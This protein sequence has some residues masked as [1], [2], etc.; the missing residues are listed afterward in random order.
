MRRSNKKITNKSN[1]S[2]RSNKNNKREKLVEIK[3]EPQ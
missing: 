1:R 2:N 3:K